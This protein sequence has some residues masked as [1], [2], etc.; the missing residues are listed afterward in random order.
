MSLESLSTLASIGTFVVIAASAIAAFVQ[1]RHMRGTNSITAL[2]E[3]REVMES[4]EFRAALHFIVH[5]LPQQL[6][7][8]SVRERLRRRPL[9][10]ELSRISVVGN[11]YENLGGYIQFG[12]VDKDVA[13]SFWSSI[14][15]QSWDAVTPALA[16][17]RRTIGPLLWEQF[18]YLAKISK[19]W[20]ADHPTGVYPRG[21]ARLPVEDVWLEADRLSDPHSAP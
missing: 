11:F 6:K 10:A 13:L 9:D 19:Q 5:A 12:I 17:M 8:P 4:E 15:V 16:I 1:L 20:L 18:E 7:D 2:T 14:V 21:L 3:C